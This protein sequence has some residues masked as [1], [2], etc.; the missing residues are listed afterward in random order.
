MTTKSD[1]EWIE[2]LQS[3][4]AQEA[5]RAVMT[6]R[7]AVRKTAAEVRARSEALHREHDAVV[8]ATH[9]AP[10]L[11]ELAAETL[12]DATAA[13]NRPAAIPVE[14]NG[15]SGNT[16]TAAESDRGRRNPKETR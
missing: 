14:D 4:A 8:L 7:D 10:V 11:M 6:A 2:T 1:A 15:R 3:P 13:G 16:T 12:L 5:V 9:L